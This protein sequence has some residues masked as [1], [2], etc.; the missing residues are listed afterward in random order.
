MHSV[1]ELYVSLVANQR[2]EVPFTFDIY[3]PLK[4]CQEMEG[5]I[6]AQLATGVL[7]GSKNCEQNFPI[8]RLQHRLNFMCD[9]AGRRSA[10]WG[11]LR[12]TFVEALPEHLMDLHE[13]KGGSVK[14]S[15]EDMVAMMDECLLEQP[16]D[17]QLVDTLTPVAGR[18]AIVT[19][20]LEQALG[21]DL[22]RVSEEQH[23]ME[24]HGP[25]GRTLPLDGITPEALQHLAADARFDSA[26]LLE[27]ANRFRT[28]CTSS[29]TTEQACQHIFKADGMPPGWTDVVSPVPGTL[30][31]THSYRHNTTGAEQKIP[32]AGT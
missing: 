6:I 23:E 8:D 29:F 22:T 19:A 32:P 13:C 17:C 1:F 26:T 12:A 25:D 31:S 28:P 16:R 9:D 20:E 5:S 2:R 21:Q 3:T 27:F 14:I 4:H 30:Y 10:P 7:D 15:R 18:D 11:S 24:V